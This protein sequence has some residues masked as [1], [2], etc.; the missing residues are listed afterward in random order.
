MRDA[1][2]QGGVFIIQF[3]DLNRQYHSFKNELDTAVFTCL[4]RGDFISGAAVGELES[5]LAE[6]CGVKHCVTCA[7]GT[8][9]LVIALRAWDI[10]P[11]DA[12]FV[13]DFT[14][15]ASA[16]CVGIVGATPIFVDVDEESFNLS[17][18]HLQKAIDTVRTA[19]KLKPRVVIPVDLFGLPANYREIEK[20][21]QEE[22][23]LL[24]ED[25]AQGF[26]GRLDGRVAGSFGQCA[27]TS[28]F[29]AKPLGCYGD[30]GAIFTND[31]EL[32]G[33]IR[34]LRVHGKGDSKYDNVRIGYNSRLDTLQA[35]VLKV[36]LAHFPAEL[37]A[38][39]WVAE[40]YDS[41]L[42]GLKTPVV[43]QGF[44][45]SWAQYTLRFESKVQRDGV[46]MALAKAGIPTN[47]YYE[48][49]MGQMEA[50]KFTARQQA[51]R[52]VTAEKLAQTVL[53]LPVHPYL[54]E[55]EINCVV[56]NVFETL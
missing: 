24:L 38:V 13:P 52:S 46:K 31:D 7:N 45:S 27:T 48:K 44:Y 47:I 39:N 4:E 37:E 50:F 3:R 16:E 11:G 30:G 8:D 43:P 28:F 36:K 33:I 54:R 35:E 56:K 14:F 12:V 10:G 5:R 34:S 2:E 42:K 49:T 17:P 40:Q 22:G 53:S 41:Q 15:F 6:Y 18:K 32:A 1:T 19:G 26:G 20:I 23:L 55:E 9:A 29:P 21:A 25:A 51:G